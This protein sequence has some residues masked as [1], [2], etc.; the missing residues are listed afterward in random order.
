[1]YNKHKSNKIYKKDTKYTAMKSSVNPSMSEIM[2]NVV[3][4][5]MMM[6]MFSHQRQ[7]VCDS[8]FS[9]L[10]KV[11]KQ[12]KSHQMSKIKS[13]VNTNWVGLCPET[14]SDQGVRSY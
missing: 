12:V 9:S 5:I 14:E 10:I 11:C 3:S 4:E 8:Q 7:V 13:P 1:M 6:M 2:N